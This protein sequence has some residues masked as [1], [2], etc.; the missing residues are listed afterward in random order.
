MNRKDCLCVCFLTL[1]YVITQE[2]ERP[3]IR[4]AELEYESLKVNIKRSF[5]LLSSENIA[6]NSVCWHSILRRPHCFSILAG[7][8]GTKISQLVFYCF[9][10]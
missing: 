4:G 2:E 6:T 3:P 1:V 8:T 10:V 7:K 5:L 9:E